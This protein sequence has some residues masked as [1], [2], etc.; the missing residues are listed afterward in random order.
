MI[1]MKIRI[2]ITLFCLVLASCIAEQKPMIDGKYIDPSGEQTITVRG[3]RIHFKIA[4]EKGHRGR[5]VDHEYDYSILPDGR[6][7]P[8][9]LVSTDV[10]SGVAKFDW[11][12][13]GTVITRTDPTTKEALIFRTQ[14]ASPRQD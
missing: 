1:T 11:F 12:W 7:Q 10:V 6:I 13:N 8:K 3:L 9:P 5:Y 2:C 4:L 14:P